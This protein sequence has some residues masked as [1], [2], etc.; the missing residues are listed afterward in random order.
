MRKLITWLGDLAEPVGLEIKMSGVTI[1]IDNTSN[2]FTVCIEKD[3]HKWAGDP[4]FGP[5]DYGMKTMG[6]ANITWVKEQLAEFL[7][8]QWSEK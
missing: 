7:D 3:F 2:T 5:K 4:T 8:R 6:Q 1:L